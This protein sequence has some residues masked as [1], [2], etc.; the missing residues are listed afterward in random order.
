MLTITST[1]DPK[2]LRQFI[3]MLLKSKTATEIKKANYISSY[4]PDENNKKIRKTQE[5]ILIIFFEE[6]KKEKL[7]ALLNKQKNISILN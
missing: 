6:T 2:S 5:K 4:K 1:L 7:L 3:I